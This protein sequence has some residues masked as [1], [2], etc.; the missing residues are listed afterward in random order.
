M[1]VQ[2][3]AVHLIV[4]WVIPPIPQRGNRHCSE[5][6]SSEASEEGQEHFLQLMANLKRKEM[7]L[8]FHTIML[9]YEIN[10][11][12]LYPDNVVMPDLEHL[13]LVKLLL[14]VYSVSA[15]TVCTQ[16]SSRPGWESRWPSQQTLPSLC[17]SIG[18]GE[19]RRPSRQCRASMIGW[20]QW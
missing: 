13:P 8:A 4:V 11:A 9:W 3:N 7:I 16:A 10:H 2:T 12:I 17:G 1:V 18:S 14:D 6:V 19:I 15:L 20:V 5:T